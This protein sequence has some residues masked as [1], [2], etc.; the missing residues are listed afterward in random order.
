MTLNIPEFPNFRGQSRSEGSV[1]S[2]SE[3]L[4]RGKIARKYY[5]T[6]KCAAGIL[7]RAAKRSRELPRILMDALKALV[8]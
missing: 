3:V 1:S 8:T 7:R 6:A 4:Y 5:L 2:L